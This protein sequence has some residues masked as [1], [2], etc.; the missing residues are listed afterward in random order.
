MNLRQLE[1]IRAVILCRTSVDA[2]KRLGLSQ[3]AVSNA[4]KN[5]ESQLGFALFDRVGGRLIPTEE[6]QLVLYDSESIFTIHRALLNKLS[7]LKEGK[8]NQLRII[9]TPPLGTALFPQIVARFMSRRPRLRLHF[10]V[11]PFDVVYEKI[12]RN[13]ADIGFVIGPWEHETFNA[14]PIAKGDMVCIVNRKHRLS[15]NKTITITDLRNEAVVAINYSSPLGGAIL[16][17]FVNSGETIVPRV[18]AQHTT[19]AC[20]LVENEVGVAIVDPFV[21]NSVQRPELLSVKPFTPAT[22]ATV[23]AIWSK[24]KPLSR[25]TEAFLREVKSG[26]D[27]S[28]LFRAEQA[29]LT[30]RH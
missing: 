4:I 11:Q 15:K 16:E 18:E 25:M 12:E 20:A 7:N 26:F 13:V 6:A 14:E 8:N 28:S 3:P 2:A 30:L 19:T 27:G 22:T 24:S 10:D 21:I 29:A 5:I 1:I 17:I 9:T 23:Y